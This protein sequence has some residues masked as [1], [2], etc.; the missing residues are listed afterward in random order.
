MKVGDQS[1]CTLVGHRVTQPSPVINPGSPGFWAKLKSYVVA[2]KIGVN[3]SVSAR[4]P[5]NMSSEMNDYASSISPQSSVSQRV[6]QSSAT[7]FSESNP[8]PESV[9]KYFIV[10]DTPESLEEAKR[11][12]SKGASVYHFYYS[13]NCTDSLYN[14]VF[15]QKGIEVSGNVARVL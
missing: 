7:D 15:L 2:A 6:V 10:K 11:L 5:A 13:V 1:F 3:L 12:L 14:L 9:G 4:Q 8:T